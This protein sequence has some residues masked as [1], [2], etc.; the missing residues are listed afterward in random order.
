MN[1]KGDAIVAELLESVSQGTVARDA[2]EVGMHYIL[3]YIKSAGGFEPISSETEGGAQ[4]LKL[5][6]GEI[7]T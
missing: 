6:E 4:S 7:T 2:D 1:A 5:K 3:D